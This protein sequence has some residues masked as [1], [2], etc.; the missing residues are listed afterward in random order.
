MLIP[1]FEEAA[2]TNFF[3]IV[4]ISLRTCGFFIPAKRIIL[5]ENCLRLRTFPDKIRLVCNYQRLIYRLNKNRFLSEY[6]RK[7]AIIL[8]L[9]L[10]NLDRI[11]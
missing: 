10:A 6:L 9:K 2:I 11:N 8:T 1:T 3:L 4:Y 5:N 7:D